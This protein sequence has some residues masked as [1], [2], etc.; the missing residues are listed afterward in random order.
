VAERLGDVIHGAL[1]HGFHRRAHAG[2]TGHDQH[3]HAVEHVDGVGARRA[4]QTQV[5]DDQIGAGQI[6][7]ILKLLHGSRFHDLVTVALQQPAQGRADDGFV[8]NHQNAGHGR[9]SGDAA[10]VTVS[11]CS[12]PGRVSTTWV[13]WP[14]WLSMLMEPP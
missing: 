5:S 8:F 7:Q 9:T 2:E 12:A 11:A 10:R 1:L 3:R 6:L 13:P 4:G 14:G